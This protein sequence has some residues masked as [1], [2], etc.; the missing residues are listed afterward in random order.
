MSE[1]EIVIPV[2]KIKSRVDTSN[3][4]VDKLR[5]EAE[6]ELEGVATSR[7]QN[8]RDMEVISG[9]KISV[10]FP[11][12]IQLVATHDFDEIIERHKYEDLVISSDLLVDL[13]GSAPVSEEV[14]E[15]KFSW[16][17]LGLMMGLIGTSI[18][19]LVFVN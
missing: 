11:K 16:V 13:A 18:V 8:V 17:F 3:S 4:L 2:S 1:R 15:S 9:G 12:F 14:H 10:K 19:F 6:A 7:S 5:M